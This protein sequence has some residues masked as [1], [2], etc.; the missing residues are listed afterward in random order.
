MRAARATGARKKAGRAMTSSVHWALLGLVIDRASYAWELAN[1]FQRVYA[2]VLPVSGASH[3]YGALD[4]L[5]ARGMIEVVPGSESVRQPKPHYRATPFGL[6]SYE[7]WVVA[8]VDDQRRRQVLWVRQLGIFASD[9]VAALRVIGR[10]ER[11]YLEGAGQIGR[12]LGSSGAASRA[13]LLDELVVEEHR[14]A[15]GGMLSWF[16]FAQTTF[17]ARAGKHQVHDP[18]RT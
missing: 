6:S 1:R 17:E 7:D 16:R 18:P 4:A 8:Q 14:L 9:P 11:R 5:K 2:D 3:I 10:C 15:A 12:S 13:E